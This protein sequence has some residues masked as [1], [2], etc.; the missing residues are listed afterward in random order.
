M[1]KLIIAVI[2]RFLLVLAGLYLII[3]MANYSDP[4]IGVERN[5]KDAFNPKNIV[6]WSP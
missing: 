2:V 1:E 5:F 3:G 6:G 4:G